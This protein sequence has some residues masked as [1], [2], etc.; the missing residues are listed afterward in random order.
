MGLSG[1][2]T[3][4][5]ILK[6]PSITARVTRPSLRAF[7]ALMATEGQSKACKLWPAQVSC[8]IGIGH[9]QGDRGADNFG[10][11]VCIDIGKICADPRASLNHL[12]LLFSLGY[13]AMHFYHYIRSEC[14][15]HQTY[16]PNNSERHVRRR[17][18]I[19]LRVVVREL[20]L[21]VQL[22][23]RV[24]RPGQSFAPASPKNADKM[25]DGADN[26]NKSVPKREYKIYCVDYPKVDVSAGRL[27]NGVLCSGSSLRSRQSFHMSFHP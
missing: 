12:V 15:S 5:S 22:D 14:D 1:T 26:H 3:C 20:R 17:Q 16:Q 2:R 24:V 4:A 13:P 6:C 8:F 9:S 21:A 7:L 11:Q 18:P 25:K 23:H 27:L 10:V 19:D